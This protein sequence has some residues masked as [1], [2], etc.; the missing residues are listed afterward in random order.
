MHVATHVELVFVVPPIAFVVRHASN[1]YIS[2]IYNNTCTYNNL[3]NKK[4]KQQDIIGLK[5]HVAAQA[6]VVHYQHYYVYTHSNPHKYI[7]IHLQITR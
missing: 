5:A 7:A 6:P 1:H 3:K 4:Q 2:N